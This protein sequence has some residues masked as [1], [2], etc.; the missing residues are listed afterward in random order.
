LTA[1]ATVGSFSVLATT[2]GVAAPATFNLLNVPVTPDKGYTY[3]LPFLANTYQPV[4]PSV[5]HRAKASTVVSGTFTTFLAFQNSSNVS[6]TVSLRYFDANGVSIATP[7]GTCTNIPA[8]GECIAPNPFA[9]GQH[10]EA[11]LTSL[12]PL[13]VIVAEATPFGGGAYTVGAGASN[14]LVAPVSIRGG[15]VDF[16]TEL[17][18]FNMA[19]SPVSGT[20]QFFDAAGNHISAA[21]KTFTLGSQTTLS[22]D[23]SSDTSLGNNFYGW[24]QVNSPTGSQLVAQ[25]LEQRPSVHF[26]AIVNA[27]FTP[28]TTLYAPAIFNQAFG[29]FVTGANLV[30]PNSTPVAVNLTY[31]RNDG[32]A[33]PTS[34]FTIPA[35]GVVGIFQGSSGGTGLPVGGLPV[36]ANG[37]YG[38][39]Q[40][41]VSGSSG[42]VMFVNEQGG[43][44]GSGS[45]Q[46][47]TYGAAVSGVTSVGL[48]VMANVAFG[49]YITGA[50][51]E[52]TTNS[53]VGGAIQYYA[54][55]GTPVGTAK[56]FSVGPHASYPVYQ[57]DPAQGLAVGFYGTAVI[58]VTSGPT[59]SLLT[60]TNAQSNQFFY[61]YTEPLQ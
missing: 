29:P 42:I 21:D 17:N 6:T 10:G 54:L 51:I 57:G 3:A 4:S 18:I 24:A 11:I 36:G 22:Y 14:M 31:Y 45:D 5:M 44:T 34:Q 2:A 56:P 60:T 47:G 37:W 23:Q 1:N 52:N 58:S 39:A 35:N 33:F 12:Q 16:T 41:T 50:T 27:Q 7:A 48:P 40:V 49:G 43:T 32:T 25:V 38:S 13:N 28:Q 20:V 19:S 59:S 61:S 26:V 53:V 15:L 55:D 8:Y 46:S 9:T 30:N